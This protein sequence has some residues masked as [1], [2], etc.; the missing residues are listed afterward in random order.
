[1]KLEDVKKIKQTSDEKTVNQYLEAGYKIIKIF[2]TKISTE[3]GDFVQ[4]TYVLGKA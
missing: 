1:M 3:Q 4:P 2:S